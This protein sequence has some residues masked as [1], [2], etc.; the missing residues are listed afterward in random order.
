MMKDG[1]ILANAGH[2]DIELD[3]AAIRRIS[4]PSRDRDN[5][6]EFEMEDGR[7]IAEGRLVNLGAAEGIPRT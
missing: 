4:C 5:L 2:F 3:L 6:E 7:V 1:V